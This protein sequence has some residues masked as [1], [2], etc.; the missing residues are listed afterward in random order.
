MR[1]RR[2]SL[3]RRRRRAC[4]QAEI[5]VQGNK[6]AAAYLVTGAS[7][8]QLYASYLASLLD[9]ACPPACLPRYSDNHSPLYLLFPLPGLLACFSLPF[10]A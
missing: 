9:P 5:Q 1:G 2:M 3:R 8:G 7:R 10:P 4:S 6:V